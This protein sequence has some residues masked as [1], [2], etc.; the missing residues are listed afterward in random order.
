MS[1]EGGKGASARYVLSAENGSAG[2]VMRHQLAPYCNE[3]K[4]IFERWRNADRAFGAWRSDL[5][6]RAEGGGKANRKRFPGSRA[7]QPREKL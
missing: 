7:R 3:Q 2:S 5:T 4:F 1:D 6:P